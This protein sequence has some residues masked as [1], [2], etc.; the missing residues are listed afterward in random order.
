M[1]SLTPP[2]KPLTHDERVVCDT[3]LK[4]VQALDSLT[5][6]EPFKLFIQRLQRRADELADEVLHHDMMPEEREKRRNHR[7][8]I[9]EVLR[10]PRED[11]EASVRTL[12]SYGMRPGETDSDLD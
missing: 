12:A 11:R 9:M 6:S 2:R 5:R 3:S 1:Q 8:G 10:V 4:T 7:L